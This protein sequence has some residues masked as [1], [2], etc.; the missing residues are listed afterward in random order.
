MPKKIEEMTNI[1]QPYTQDNEIIVKFQ[2]TYPTGEHYDIEI[3]ADADAKN[4]HP[5]IKASIEIR[6]NFGP[7]HTPS[8]HFPPYSIVARY[9]TEAIAKLQQELSPVPGINAATLT[10]LTRYAWH[11]IVNELYKSY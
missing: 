6:P 2:F 5:G 9:D 4:Y 8:D 7:P 1:M 3:R 11:Q 10:H